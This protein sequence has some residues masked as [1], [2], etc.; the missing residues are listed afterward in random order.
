MSNL[1]AVSDARGQKSTSIIPLSEL[2]RMRVYAMSNNGNQTLQNERN[3][4]KEISDARTKKWPN[5]VQAIRKKKDQERFEKFKKEELERRELEKDEAAFQAKEKKKL[6]DRSKKQIYDG[7]D[8]N[9][10]GISI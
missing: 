9:W 1:S 10:L 2:N 3:Y 5:T 7:Y 4:L 6:L 8:Q